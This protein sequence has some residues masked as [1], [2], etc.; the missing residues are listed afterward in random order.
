M[1]TL[2]SSSGPS[3]SKVRVGT[4]LL[5]ESDSAMQVAQKDAA[6]FLTFL[7][8]SQ[9]AYSYRLKLTYLEEVF[10]NCPNLEWV[11][12]RYVGLVSD[13]TLLVL[14]EYCC[15]LKHLFVE[16]CTKVTENTLTP[17]RKFGIN[18]DIPFDHPKG[19]SNY[20]LGQI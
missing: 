7:P 15:K 19:E 5:I 17:L 16:G 2:A 3:P 13:R 6:F 20:I 8:P 14:R 4:P 1:H 10:K 9:V 18:V 11:D 12:V